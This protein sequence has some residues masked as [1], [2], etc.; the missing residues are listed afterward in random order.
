[1]TDDE[2]ERK[3][4]E[5]LTTAPGDKPDRQGSDADQSAAPRIEATETADGV[6]RID[7]ADTAAVRPGSPD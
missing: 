4:R 7:V 6:T 5:Q 1:M 3:R 2:F